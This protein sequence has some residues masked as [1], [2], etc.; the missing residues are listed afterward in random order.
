MKN[1]KSLMAECSSSPAAALVRR[2]RGKTV[3]PPRPGATAGSLLLERRHVH[4]VACAQ[5]SRAIG[6]NT[7]AM[8]DSNSA[9]K[10][11]V[12]RGCL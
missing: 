11:M 7:N 10:Q 2:E 1:R 3:M 9:S 6:E 4:F 12:A 5:Y 8:L